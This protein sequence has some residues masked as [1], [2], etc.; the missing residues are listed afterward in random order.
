MKSLGMNYKFAVCAQPLKGEIVTF[1]SFF[2]KCEDQNP[3]TQSISQKVYE[4]FN[5]PVCKL[6]VQKTPDKTFLC[7]LEPVS[8]EELTDKDL[9]IIAKEVTLILEQGEPFVVQNSLFC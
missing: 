6:H 4:T 3:E 1:K 9:K 8:K 5:I 2:G 7:G